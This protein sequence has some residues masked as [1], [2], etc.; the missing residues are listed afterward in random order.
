MLLEEVGD[1]THLKVIHYTGDSRSARNKNVGRFPFHDKA[2]VRREMVECDPKK[3]CV[4]V[5]KYDKS[6]KLFSNR[7]ERALNRIGEQEY[8]LFYNNCESFVNEVSV[9]KCSSIQAEW[10]TQRQDESSELPKA[11]EIKDTFKLALDSCKDSSSSDSDDDVCVESGALGIF[12]CHGPPSDPSPAG[13]QLQLSSKS[14]DLFQKKIMKVHTEDQASTTE[15]TSKSHQSTSASSHTYSSAS[16]LRHHELFL[17]LQQKSTIT[18][19]LS[20]KR[21]DFLR[22]TDTSEH[23]STGQGMCT[24][25]KQNRPDEDASGII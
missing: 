10:F 24:S 3:Y 14:F 17:S 25:R 9:G 7:I 5:V 22:L 13:S 11:E 12:N 4:Y 1:A 6:E 21:T 18:K 20:K 23:R 15:D 16:V 8:S 19:G 2:E